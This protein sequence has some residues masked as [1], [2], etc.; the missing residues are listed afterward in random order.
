M[1]LV[2]RNIY[3]SNT[4]LNIDYVLS[5]EVSELKQGITKYYE[6]NLKKHII[7][8]TCSKNGVLQNKYNF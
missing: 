2:Y 5:I 7:I 6:P 4:V 1:I 8:L 3:N